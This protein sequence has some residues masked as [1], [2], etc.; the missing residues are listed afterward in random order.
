M[1]LCFKCLST[2][3]SARSCQKTC[4]FWRGPH[5]STLHRH[6]DQFS[7]GGSAQFRDS[8]HPVKQHPR[9]SINSTP[10]IALRSFRGATQRLVLTFQRHRKIPQTPTMRATPS[11]VRGASPL[12]CR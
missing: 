7:T 2:K 1:K 3:H 4:F 8:R 6:R 5:H 9:V 10:L 11:P 12:L